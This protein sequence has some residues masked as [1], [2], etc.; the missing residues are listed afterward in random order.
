MTGS[1]QMESERR[2]EV[3]G[4]ELTSSL[5]HNKQRVMSNY[6]LTRQDLHFYSHTRP[7]V[8]KRPQGLVKQNA[9]MMG[10]CSLSRQAGWL[11]H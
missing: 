11:C 5:P 10:P 2:V 4:Q 9:E 3:N 7:E 1:K 6:L 8:K